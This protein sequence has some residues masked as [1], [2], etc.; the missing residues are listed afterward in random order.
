MPPLSSACWERSVNYRLLS[1]IENAPAGFEYRPFIEQRDVRR[2]PFA[3]LASN[4]E[5][6]EAALAPFGNPLAG[7]IVT[8]GPEQSWQQCGQL[9]FHLTVPHELRANLA[10][11]LHSH[12]DLLGNCHQAENRNAEQ[13]LNLLRAREDSNR[14]RLEFA[15]IKESLV[16]ELYERRRAEENLRES[17]LFL[18][19]VIENTG[20]LIYAKDREGRYELVNRKWEEETGLKREL[21]I[22]R[23]D[24]ELFSETIGTEFRR[25]DLHVMELESVL[26][27]EELFEDATGKRFFLSIKIPLRDKNNAVKGICG[28]ST[29]ITER[30]RVEE[31][32]RES[33]E[34]Y[35]TLFDR[36]G[37]GI[38]ILSADGKLVEVNESLARM[39]GY[40]V[41]EMQQMDL[42]DL[43]TPETFRQSPERMRRLL[44]GETLTFEVEHYHKDGH[45]FPL[46]VSASLISSGGESYIHCFHRDITYRRQAE[47]MLIESE[48]R[49][50]SLM[51]DIPTVAVQGYALDGTVLFWNRASEQLYGYSSEEA[52]GGNLLDLIIPPEMCEGVKGAIRQMIETGEPIPAGELLLRRKDGSRVPVFS[53]HALVNPVG[54]Q[55]ELFCLDIDLTE[56]KQ[57]EEALLES[58]YRWKFAI[59]GSGDGVWDWNIQ[60]DEAKYSR[61]WKEMLGYA[62]NDILPANQEWVDRI[63][64]EDQSHVAG[65][66]QAYLEG[67]TEIYVVEYRL[68]CKD[69]SY[70]WILGRG[71][72][73]SRSEDGRPLRMIGTHTDITERKEHEKEQLKIDKLESL[74]ILAGGIAHDFNNILTGIMGNISFA[75]MFLDAGHRSYKPLVEAE[76]ASVRASELAHQLLTFARGGEPV[77]KVVSLPHLVKETVSLVLHGSNVIGTVDIPDSIHAI[78]ADEGQLSQVFHNIIINATQA[79]PGG[80]TLTVTA[81]NEN[82]SNANRMALPGGSYVRIS[83]TDQGCGISS[84]DLKRIFDPYFT[85]KSAGNGLGLASAH[86]IV[87][88]HGGHISASSE[89]GKGTTFTI[90]LPSI[91]KSY[92]N[93][94]TGTVTHSPGEH[95]GGSIL[96]MDDE[97]MILEM[98]TDMLEYLGYQVK[99]CKNG[100][101]TIMEYMAAREAGA[102]FSAVI[103]DLTIPGGMGGRET[104]GQILAIDP[105]ACLIVSSGYSND[106]II[107]EYSRYGF[108][109]AVAKPYR[110]LE[111][112]QLLSSLF[113]GQNRAV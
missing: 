22:G 93:Y 110:I 102:P 98:T 45:V 48:E 69:E 63:H 88:R 46:E 20:A 91:G 6:A 1:L 25:A 99:T 4:R 10:A 105:D 107:S 111:L 39:H 57:A 28:I 61:R 2:W 23:T 106:P 70:K 24:M 3:L 89:V 35:R 75:Q 64:P 18:S 85:T 73:V 38:F 33:E 14:N 113:S 59:E 82:L 62:E 78:E 47:E 108:K 15:L 90:H 34:R 19:E 109:A 81:D 68:R 84:D 67:K 8:F 51:E 37:D 83:F 9:L 101:E 49:F 103:M 87:N 58:E 26:E 80:G 112:G 50:R 92:S 79:M 32:L 56:R 104:A 95:T 40:S 13:E 74:G 31:A 16:E 36:A 97:E 7:I 12:L 76:K 29:E 11:L 52:L 55:P 27:L 43:D 96:V 66:M 54:R 72:V 30:K 44:A 86:S 100:A 21:V 53:S 94:Q 17:Q 41:Q 60:S 42:R 65:V 5:E 77:K 71:M